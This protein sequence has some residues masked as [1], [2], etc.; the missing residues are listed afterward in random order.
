MCDA[1]CGVSS[2]S[3]DGRGL[4]A[5]DDVQGAVRGDAVEP[6]RDAGA[7]AEAGEPA[8]GGDE[9]LLQRVLGVV[10]VARE[11]EHDGVDPVAVAAHQ[12]VEGPRSPRW[13][14]RTSASSAVAPGTGRS[15]DGPAASRGPVYV[16]PVRTDRAGL[17]AAARA[18]GAGAR[19]A[20]RRGP[21][22]GLRAGRRERCATTTSATCRDLLA[23]TTSWWS[24]PRACC[25][26]PGCAPGGPPAGGRGAAARAAAD[27]TWEALARP[28]PQAAR[29][30]RGWRPASWPRRRRAAGA[31]AGGRAA[32]A[33]GGRWRRRSSATA[34]D[35][36]AAV[37]RARRRADDRERYQTVYAASPARS[38]RRRRACTSRRRC[39][40]AAR[41]RGIEVARGRRCTSASAR[42]RRCAADD[43]DDHAMHAERYAVP[44]ET[45]A[46]R[47]RARRGRRVVAVG[48]TAVRALETAAAR[49][50]GVRRRAGRRALHPPGHRFRAVD[51]LL[52]NFHLPRSTLLMLVAAFAG[53]R[54]RCSRAYAT[55]SRSATA[56]TRYG[57]AMPDRV[58]ADV[59]HALDVHVEA[60]TAPRRAGSRT[61][62]GVVDTP[63]SCPSAPRHGQGARP[64]TSSSALGAQ[65]ILGNTYHLQLRPGD[66]LVARA[67]RAAPRS[68]AGTAR[69]SPTPAASRSSRSRTC[70]DGRRGRRRVPLAHRRL[71]APLH[72]RARDARSRRALGSDIAMALR[73]VPAGPTRR[74]DACERGAWRA[75]LRWAAALAA[76]PHAAP[77]PGCCFGIV[78]GGIDLDLRRAARRAISRI[79]F[80][81]YAH[82][83]AVGRRAEPDDVRTSSRRRRRAAGRPAAL[84]HGRRHPEDLV[85]RSRAASTCS[86]AC[87]RPA[88]GATAR[89]FTRDGRLN[90]R[91]ARFA[92][93]DRRR[94]TTDC[95]CPACTRFS[96][97]YMRHLVLPGRD[98]R[99]AP[100]H[101]HN[102]AF[103][104][105]LTARARP[106]SSRAAWRRS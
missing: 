98:P 80:D 16:R 68:W 94:S 26:V 10:G 34:A 63:A 31:R 14:W 101:L 21:S 45:A 48:T 29:G 77:R 36:A 81:G 2:A 70:A 54:A 40:R 35:A 105:A 62:H 4:A 57:D 38:P 67:R 41:A 74:R 106:R 59:V 42:S 104:L 30:R 91:N 103:L 71:A 43:L 44:A 49:R 86:T 58:S 23:P 75:P 76:R 69:S 51:A 50:G 56:S 8:V 32:R 61:P 46:A 15:P 88:S 96:R 1:T 3:S 55:R 53:H 85:R 52:T 90:I 12:L 6:G 65:I 39:W 60:A 95:D 84:P 33:A 82:R 24:T 97:A 73:R 7:A 37:H 17:R 13:A 25:R 20:A 87:C 18:G 28:G 66:E 78:Q 89:V 92:R 11:P 93:D 83:R 64:A 72:A 5:V 102:V 100:A 99:P 79:G 22:A 27:G 9:R 19:R 47:A